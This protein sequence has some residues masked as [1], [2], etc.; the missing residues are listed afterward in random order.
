M[1]FVDPHHGHNQTCQPESKARRLQVRGPVLTPALRRY[2]LGYSAAEP[3][4]RLRCL[5]AGDTRYHPDVVLM[6]IRMLGG[7]AG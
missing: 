7:R 3:H 1:L 2:P 4:G 5:A 6:D